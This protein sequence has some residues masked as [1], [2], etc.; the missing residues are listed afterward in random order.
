MQSSGATFSLYVAEPAAEAKQEILRGT[1]LG[2]D[3]GYAQ[4]AWSPAGDLIAFVAAQYET[5]E[6]SRVWLGTAV[7]TDCHG[8]HDIRSVDDPDS[9]V[10]KEN[11]QQTCGRCH[12]GAT[13]NFPGAWLS[14]YQP[15]LSR[16]PVVFSVK[17]FYR[18]L[19]PGMIGGLALHILLDVWRL[20]RNR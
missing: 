9:P 3:V 8:T 14:H 18:L 12:P 5:T 7:C 16:A 4:F 19:I 1:A 17:W 6:T 11:L 15:S 20:A 13:P 2:P 10:F